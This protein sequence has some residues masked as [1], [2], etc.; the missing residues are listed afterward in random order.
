MR[1]YRCG[2]TGT[3]G[4]LVALP[5]CRRRLFE[6]GVRSPRITDRG[7]IV[8]HRSSYNRC[9]VS[10]PL[11]NS[12]YLRDHPNTV[13]LFWLKVDRTAGPDACWPW[14]GAI[15][16]GYGAFHVDGRILTASRV[17]WGIQS[18]SYPAPSLQICHRCDKPLCCNPAHL[19]EG[20][21]SDNQLDSARKG[22]QN[23]AGRKSRAS[24]RR[25]H[26]RTLFKLLGSAQAVAEVLAVSEK[27][28]QK[29]LR[30]EAA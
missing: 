19:F 2:E 7:A 25:A 4:Q 12:D 16:K 14:R 10:Q 30:V 23:C 15:R 28:V 6:G 21:G 5:S 24:W 22:R 11:N 20:T 8:G 13:E 3:Y 29:L 18:G 27:R 17:A 9:N 26:I 1:A